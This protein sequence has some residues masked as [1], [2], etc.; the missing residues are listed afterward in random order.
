MVHPYLCLV[1]KIIRLLVPVC[2]ITTAEEPARLR[3]SGLGE[4]WNAWW[5]NHLLDTQKISAYHLG[6]QT[7]SV[8]SPRLLGVSELQTSLLQTVYAYLQPWTSCF[9]RSGDCSFPSKLL[10]QWREIVA[11][12]FIHLFLFL[13]ICATFMGGLKKLVSSQKDTCVLLNWRWV[14][15]SRCNPDN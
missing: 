13:R 12:P 5:S 4:M 14:L 11:S 3:H 2:G 7:N 8:L 1:N 15:C 10:Q 9:V 6:I